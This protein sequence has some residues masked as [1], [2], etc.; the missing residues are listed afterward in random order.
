VRPLTLVLA[1]VA[2]NPESDLVADDSGILDDTAT[3]DTGDDSDS[4]SAVDTDTAPP[5]LSVRFIALGDAGTGSDGQRAV[6]AQIETICAREDRGCEFALYLGDNVYDSGV[7]SATDDMFRTHFEEPYADLDFPFYVV[8]GNHD[9]GGDG[10][11]IDLDTQKAQYQ[12]DY[13]DHSDKWT[14]PD[15]YYIVPET[16]APADLVTFFAL[17]T[18]DVFYDNSDDQAAWLES[19]TLLSTSTW[20]IAFGHHPY[21][22]NGQHGNAGEYEGLPAGFDTWIY[23]VPRGEYVR[24]FVE[25]TMCDGQIDVYFAGHDHNRQWLGPASGCSTEFVVSG[26]GAKVTDFRHEE[27]DTLFEDDQTEGF[28]WVEIIDNTLTA[29]FYDKNGN[30]AG[31]FTVER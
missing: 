27:N 8:L 10:L 2:C 6:A 16:S 15:E 20:N 4:D 25:D 30:E 14:M 22:S 21:I 19:Q 11:G 23:N 28:L 31:P 9:L 12:I 18:T 24:R 5:P 1:L 3:D 17:N 13:T 7:G 26:A 29:Y